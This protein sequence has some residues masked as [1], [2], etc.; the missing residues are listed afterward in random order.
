[1]FRSFTTGPE[2]LKLL[3]ERYNLPEP[4]GM[5]ELEAA[6]WK[7]LKQTPIKLRYVNPETSAPGIFGRDSAK[8]DGAESR[9]SS[10]LGLMC[11][12]SKPRM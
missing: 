4:E 2:L 3:I 1:M 9:M 8:A 12:T 7:K 6:D 5:T 11:I 10:D